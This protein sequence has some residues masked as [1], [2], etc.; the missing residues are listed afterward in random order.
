MV[1][2]ILKQRLQGSYQPARAPQ[3][4]ASLTRVGRRCSE[5]EVKIMSAEMSSLRVKQG[6]YLSRKLGEVFAGVISG[7]L[8]FGFF[9]RLVD[10]GA[11]G[12][13]RLSWLEDDY[14][15]ANLNRLE[16]VGR[17][18]RR[19][20]RMGDKVMVQIVNV[21]PERGE[22]DLFLVEG[23]RTRKPRGRRAGRERR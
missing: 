1:H 11:E 13:V 4:K 18:S 7:V 2:R 21:A 5:M 22:I 9:V 16:I 14:Y 15:V 8:K 17:Q 23:G 19:R 10:I 12:M 6:D 3:L 20:L